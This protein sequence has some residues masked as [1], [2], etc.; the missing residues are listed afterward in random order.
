MIGAL[1]GASK[2]DLLSATFEPI[3]GLWSAAPLAPEIHNVSAGSFHNLEPPEI[4]G[5]G[6]V[7]KSM[8]AALWA[9]HK[10][11]NFEESILRAAN[12]GQ[13]ADTTAAIC[14]QLAGA[15]YGFNG[16]PDRWLEKIALA[17]TI[18]SLTRGLAR[19]AGAIG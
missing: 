16:I 11:G 5:T 19:L 7:V 17:E 15:Y 10:S 13:D 3:P 1:A 4:A 8:E 2:E 6:Y 9:F 12:L 14:G 18:E